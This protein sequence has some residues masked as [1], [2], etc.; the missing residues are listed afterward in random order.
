MSALTAAK[1]HHIAIRA[2]RAVDEP[3]TCS[4]FL[5]QHRKVLE[6]FGIEH[7][8]TNNAD[9]AKD[10]DTYLIVA[11][12]PTLGMIGGLRIE[13]L[14][15]GRKLPIV[16]ALE[17][18]DRRIEQSVRQWS[19]NGCAEICGLWNSSKFTNRGLPTLLGYAAVAIANQI[20]VGSM[21]CLIAHYT[22]RHALKVGF[23]I[24]ED[25]G[26]GGTF[27]YPIPSIKAIAMVM[28]DTLLLT[29][30]S[31]RHRL[32]VLSLRMRPVQQRVEQPGAETLV[33]DYHLQL[34]TK[35][36]DIS[37]YREVIEQRLRFSA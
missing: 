6:D 19:G 34:D 17:K 4:E 22:L 31:H 29:E 26:D 23:T 11:E 24:M 32:P 35:V 15:E 28:P 10:P 20:H 27:T 8:N 13:L 5:R 14:K 7:V 25:V 12:S 2:F 30:A 21:V 9:W 3:E 36:I 1:V 33:V 16:D 18:L 37:A